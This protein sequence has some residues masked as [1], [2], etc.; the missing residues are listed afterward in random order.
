MAEPGA[1]SDLARY[2]RRIERRWAEI[3]ERPIVLSP[4]EWTLVAAWHARGVPLALVAQAMDEAVERSRRGGRLPRRVTYL[5]SAVEEAWA[6]V[7]DGRL[8]PADPAPA[9]A[10]TAPGG[11]WRRRALD[12]A[13]GPALRGLIEE[14]LQRLAAG[15]PAEELDREL[16]RRLV[17]CVPPALLAA[18][19]A[20]IEIELAAYRER[21]SEERL[22]RTRA[23]ARIVRLRGALGLA[24][25]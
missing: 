9:P 19:D 12:P 23:R 11:A 4:R 14:L 8:G 17:A 18:V 20:G 25:L 24:R 15:E 7:L 2:V 1:A 10:A 3:Q 5:A 13:S 22:H 6:T 16:D 21:I